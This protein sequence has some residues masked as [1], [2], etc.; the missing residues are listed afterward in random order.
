MAVMMS[1]RN[2]PAFP[3]SISQ[4]KSNKNV[5]RKDEELEEGWREEI[6]EETILS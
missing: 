5:E 2:V 1:G 4:M 3:S 6:T